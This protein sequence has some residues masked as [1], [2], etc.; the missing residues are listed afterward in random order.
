MP[1]KHVMKSLAETT[2]LKPAEKSRWLDCYAFGKTIANIIIYT[3]NETAYGK[4]Y[5]K[6]LQQTQ[7]SISDVYIDKYEFG[8]K[9]T[10]WNQVFNYCDTNE[11]FI[12]DNTYTLYTIND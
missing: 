10:W 4:L 2:F 9:T 5:Y 12:F 3:S 7:V 8:L 11:K 1:S 6:W